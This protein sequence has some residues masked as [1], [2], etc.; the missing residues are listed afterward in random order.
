MLIQE[1]HRSHDQLGGS[2]LLISHRSPA[3]TDDWEHVN[4]ELVK[5]G[6]SP[7]VQMSQDVEKKGNNK[8]SCCCVV[9]YPDP[10]H[11]GGMVV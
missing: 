7:V 6:Y 5:Y 11:L 4:K 10:Y 2:P 3:A 8:T 1:H 9:S